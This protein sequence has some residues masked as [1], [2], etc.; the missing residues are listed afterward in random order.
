[1]ELYSLCQNSAFLEQG[2]PFSHA[3]LAEISRRRQWEIE[4]IYPYDKSDA[5]TE[6]GLRIAKAC[7]CETILAGVPSNLYP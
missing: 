5:N 6:L 4:M 7:A 3:I 1:M 2:A